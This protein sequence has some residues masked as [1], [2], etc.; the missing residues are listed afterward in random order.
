MKN[1]SRAHHFAVGHSRT[2]TRPQATLK[3][4]LVSG[5]VG[6]FPGK[7]SF[8]QDSGKNPG[9]NWEK[10]GKNCPKP[11]KTVQNWEKLSRTMINPQIMKI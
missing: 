4:N 6:N 7:T 9:K 3:N 8:S 2:M 1:H 11:G 10:P 5:R